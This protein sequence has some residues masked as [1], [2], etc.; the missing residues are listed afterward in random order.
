MDNDANLAIYYLISEQYFEILLS[1]VLERNDI[2]GISPLL[3]SIITLIN[4]NIKMNIKKYD[5]LIDAMMQTKNMNFDDIFSA[6]NETKDYFLQMV[7]L[8]ALSKI[9]ID[10]YIKQNPN[11][12][13]ITMFNIMTESRFYLKTDKFGENIIQNHEYIQWSGTI[14]KKNLEKKIQS[15]LFKGSILISTLG[16]ILGGGYFFYKKM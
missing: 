13:D 6:F 3:Q 12:R 8:F 15:R 9:S 5:D 10:K 2:I 1:N 14:P 7:I 11:K 16:L 4:N